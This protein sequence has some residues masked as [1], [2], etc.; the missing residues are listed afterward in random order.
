[1][2]RTGVEEYRSFLESH[3]SLTAR[4]AGEGIEPLEVDT[5]ASVRWKEASLDEVQLIIVTQEKS[6]SRC[7]SRGCSRRLQINENKLSFCQAIVRTGYKLLRSSIIVPVSFPWDRR[8][9]PRNFLHPRCSVREWSPETNITASSTSWRS[10]RWE[11][12]IH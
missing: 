12:L 8:L 9:P 2:K 10:Y 1:M 4:H 6:Y 3:R 7:V 11:N 5:Q